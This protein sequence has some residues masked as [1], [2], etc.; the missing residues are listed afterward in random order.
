ML[1]CSAEVKIPSAFETHLFSPQM[2]HPLAGI[3]G[4][5][6]PTNGL[7][8]GLGNFTGLGFSDGIIHDELFESVV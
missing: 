3:L 7:G 1:A 5:A 4:H 8:F 6:I 2:E